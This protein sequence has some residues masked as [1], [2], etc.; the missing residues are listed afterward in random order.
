MVRHM[1]AQ[2][3]E[4]VKPRHR[5]GLYLHSKSGE[6]YILQHEAV[7]TETGEVLCVYTCFTSDSV[8]VRPA[9]MWDEL[10]E[11]DGERVPRF[12]LLEDRS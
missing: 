8:W 9:Q 10:V 2:V 6:Q 5:P 12:Q 7:H 3:A 1:G 4:N 11:V